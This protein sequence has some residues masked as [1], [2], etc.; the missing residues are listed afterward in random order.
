MPII[1]LSI[2]IQILCAVH[3]VRNNRNSMWLMVII[4]LSI[5]GCLA[6]AIFEIFPAYAGRR[7]V[8]AAKAVAIRKLDPQRD[9]RAAREALDL[10]DTA[11][12][13]IKLGDALVELETWAEAIDHFRRALGK[14]AGSD[15]GTQLKLARAELAA[16]RVREAREHLE[17]LP[18]SGS[19]SE[20][21]RAS[22][23]LAQAME[24][25]GDRDRALELYTEVGNR[26]PG[27]EAQCRAAALL[28]AMGRPGEA[29]AA[30]EEVERILK[31]LDRFERNQRRDMYEWAGRTLKELRG[32]A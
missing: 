8:R 29:Q 9:L 20:N 13:R 32:P 23:L 25:C 26:L 15:R 27:G 19:P 10:A 7:E 11:A 3:C 2:V 4:F 22:L 18:E 5:P 17:S 14:T 6:Y 24:E 12:N 21:D 1:G 30:L 28:I 31:R 16:G